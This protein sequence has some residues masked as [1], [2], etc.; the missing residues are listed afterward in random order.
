MTATHERTATSADIARLDERLDALDERMVAVEV[1][2][3]DHTKRFDRLDA[4]VDALD[5]K[6]DAKF[7]DVLS[8]L[9]R[10]E[11]FLG[12]DRRP[13]PDRGVPTA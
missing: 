4:K 8:R 12:S 3:N 13:M 11:G 7:A 2:V 10:I 1:V 5:A 9:E 6:V